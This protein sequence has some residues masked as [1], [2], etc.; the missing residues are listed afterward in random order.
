MNIVR[1]SVLNPQI[2]PQQIAR[3]SLR[4][5]SVHSARRQFNTKFGPY[6]TDYSSLA[7]HSKELPDWKPI[8]PISVTKTANPHW[9]FGDGASKERQHKQ[10]IEI[11]PFAEGR[12]W[13]HNYTLLVSGIVP[14]PIGFVSTIGGDGTKNLA[15]FSYFQVVDHN[16]PVFVFG[17]TGREQRPKD[18]LRNLEETGE[19]V[20][21][22][23]SE[24][25]IDAV[26]AS[27]ID[28]PYAGSEW[29]LSGLN[30]APS[31][32]VRPSRVQ[33]SI[34]SI[35]G[36][37]LKVVD[38]NTS[39]PSSG[40]H[41]RLAI[42]EGTRFWVRE[43]AINEQHSQI[44]LDVLR[45]IGQLGGISYARISETFELARSN[46]K[47]AQ[48]NGGDKLKELVNVKTP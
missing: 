42:I 41:G 6:M 44:D 26:N 4:N 35:E 8:R 34:F 27:S 12:P 1:G 11:D 38:F 23:V 47:A 13:F 45:P 30:E 15:P 46:W 40:P 43:D 19:C 24:H 17:F 2:L 9:D 21:N 25:M 28:I 33:E 36:R 10:H 39:K 20:I 7:S 48:V 31:S 32:T 29:T 37:L 18:T 22:I 5:Q 16:P 3:H 14:R